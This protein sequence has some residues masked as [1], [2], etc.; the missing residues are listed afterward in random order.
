MGIARA[1]ER[2]GP[3]LVAL[4][5]IGPRA[6]VDLVLALERRL[7]Y[8][9]VHTS[10]TSSAT[11]TLSRFPILEAEPFTLS[12]EGA[13]WCHRLVIDAPGGP[14]TLLNI[15]TKIPRLRRSRLA[16]GRLAVPTS[17]SAA[18]RLAE[19]R[20]LCELIDAT[21]GPLLAMGDFNMTERSEDHALIARRLTDA[22]LVAGRGLG[23]TFPAWLT[24][25]TGLPLPF[26]A[27]RLDHIWHSA[28]FR[29]VSARVGPNAGSDHQSVIVRLART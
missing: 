23:H 29:I 19:V 11:A 10:P 16:F 22:Y 8:V 17:F 15:H 21:D 7:P 20:R 18:R 5:E 13:H 28:H 24:F 14:L 26:P 4:Q 6:A 25:P 27:V 3:D 12:P 2:L 9:A 1:I